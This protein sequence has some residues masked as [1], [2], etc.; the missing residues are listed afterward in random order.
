M[1]RKTEE[2]L[3]QWPY[4]QWIPA[5]PQMQAITLEVIIAVI[6]GVTDRGLLARPE[7]PD[8]NLPRTYW[9]NCAVL[10]GPAR[11]R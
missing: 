4:G 9:V 10:H 7:E 1:R 2:A 11:I 5:Q 8:L 6:F 3:A